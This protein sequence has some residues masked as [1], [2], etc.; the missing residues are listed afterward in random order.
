MNIEDSM[1]SCGVHEIYGLKKSPRQNIK[2]FA[3][4]HWDSYEQEWW[5][6]VPFVIFSDTVK[7]GSGQK[8]ADFITSNDL[9]IVRTLRARTNPNSGNKIKV[10]LWSVNIPE[11]KTYANKKNPPY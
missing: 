9:G 5:E 8:L 2:D 3:Q 6:F 1:V 4:Q 10:W 11:V 7:S